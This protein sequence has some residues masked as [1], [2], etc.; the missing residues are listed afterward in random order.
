MRRE[1]TTSRAIKCTPTKLPDG[2]W[3]VWVNDPD[4]E[5][6][7]KIVI[8]TRGGDEWYGELD[9]QEQGKKWSY[10]KLGDR[11]W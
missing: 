4:A 5:Q 2:S 10:I 1:H 7:D 8:L 6:G 11:Y 9:E 3:G